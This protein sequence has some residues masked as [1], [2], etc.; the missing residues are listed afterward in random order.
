MS[1]SKQQQHHSSTHSWY[2]NRKQHYWVSLTFQTLTFQTSPK[3]SRLL[4]AGVWATSSSFCLQTPSSRETSLQVF[5]RGM[6]STCFF[7]RNLPMTLIGRHY[8][9]DGP[10]INYY[11][12][13]GHRTIWPSVMSNGLIGWLSYVWYAQ[14][15]AASYSTAGPMGCQMGRST[16]RGQGSAVQGREGAGAVAIPN[17]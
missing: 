10:R 1:H 15:D 3:A 8:C 9:L 14:A 11:R 5:L 16:K 7:K 6:G 4:L 12:P 2:L 13:R 17:W